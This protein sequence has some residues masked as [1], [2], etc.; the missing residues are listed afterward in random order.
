[1]KN[2]PDKIP[3][4]NEIVVPS[5]RYTFAFKFSVV[6]EKYV[7]IILVTILE[8]NVLYVKYSNIQTTQRDNIKIPIP[9]LTDDLAPGEGSY[10][11]VK[12]L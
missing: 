7:K 12:G 3:K 6:K 4:L 5:E 10:V 2:I 1:M 9:K 11:Y 8:K